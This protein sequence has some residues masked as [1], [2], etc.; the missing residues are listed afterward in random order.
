METLN[1]VIVG[2]VDHGKSTLIG[3][4]LYDT[5]SLAPDKIE[6]IKKASAD[7]GRETE[8]AYLLDH[9]EEERKQGV[10][11]DTTQVF[12]KTHKRHYV[13]IDAP[14]HVEFVKNMITGASQA[15]AAVLI[16]DVAEG[17]REQ[18]KRHSYMLSLLG[19]QQIVVVLNKMDLAEFSQERFKAVKRN[20]D[21]WLKS[22]NLEPLLYVPI[23]AIS[24]DNIAVRSEKMT[25]Y[26]GP[27][28]LES[29][30][31]LQNLQPP[32]NKAVI[33]PVQDVYKVDE[34]RITAGRVEA[35][36]LKTQQPVK[37]L[38][39]GQTTRI[40]SIEKFPSQVDVATAGESIGIV[41]EEPLFLNRGDVLCEPG[42]EPMLTDI[43]DAT[44]FWMSKKPFNRKNKI[45]IRCAT[46]Q[47]A[48]KVESINKRIDSASLEI[49]EQDADSL[50]NL[51]VGEV[52]IK[53]KN[54]IAIKSFND[55]KEPGRFVFVEGDNICAGGIIAEG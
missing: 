42:A 12:F 31:S 47:A 44:I 43:F 49:I 26:E 14:G 41:T 20:V 7:R 23:A 10:T 1:F 19:L 39:S 52:T 5:D 17:V 55:V 13:I 8:F 4:L 34:K 16:V 40:K 25:W 32:E 24:G 53:T 36:V 18:T 2:H 46:Q 30:D 51:E 15:E 3:R 35:G 29:L 6:E 28:F 21:E 22:I 38:P 33:L 54:P 11:I 27:T 37:I 50:R 9:L 45:M 48:A